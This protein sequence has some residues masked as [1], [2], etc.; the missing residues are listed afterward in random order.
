MNMRLT[1]AQING[2]IQSAEM[3]WK[4][5]SDTHKINRNEF[6][7]LFKCYITKGGVVENICP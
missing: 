6:I 2:V 7:H 5:L 4:H 3:A 1:T